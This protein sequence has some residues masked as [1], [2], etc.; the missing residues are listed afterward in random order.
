M[1]FVTTLQSLEEAVYE[2]V[3]WI[4]FVPKTF[5]MS[6]LRHGAMRDYV[7]AEFQKEPYDRFR[8]FLSPVRLWLIAAVL[9]YAVTSLS[10]DASQVTLQFSIP[11]SSILASSIIVLMVIP[12][13]FALVMLLMERLP[14][15]RETL[16]RLFYIQ[17]YPA[18]VFEFLALPMAIR[19]G[20]QGADTGAGLVVASQIIFVI[21]AVWFLAAETVIFR[22]ELGLSWPAAL[23][24]AGLASIV[25]LVIL[26][27]VAAIYV[28]LLFVTGDLQMPAG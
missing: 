12:L 9:P 22:N 15:E 19:I 7:N 25:S 6:F 21:G 5:L 2:V 14:V 16:K 17:A 3:T 28:L 13:W 18:T 8:N 10:R 23:G 27:A 24:A 26:L 4:L 20:A 11:N 1:D